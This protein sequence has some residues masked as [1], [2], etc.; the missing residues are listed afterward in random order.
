MVNQRFPSDSE[1]DF[2]QIFGVFGHLLAL[3]RR[4]KITKWHARFSMLKNGG[5]KFSQKTSQ[6][7]R[8]SR[9][10]IQPIEA[11]TIFLLEVNI[12]HPIGEIKNWSIVVLSSFKRTFNVKNRDNCRFADWIISIPGWNT[13]LA[14]FSIACQQD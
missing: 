8:L 13:I 2:W 14:V 1:A 10:V 12:F 11:E 3:K 5:Q 4:K 9:Y 7:S 6:I